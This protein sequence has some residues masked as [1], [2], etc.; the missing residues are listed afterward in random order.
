MVVK[1]VVDECSFVGRISL[2]SNERTKQDKTLY[3][4]QKR[5]IFLLFLLKTKDEIRYVPG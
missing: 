2:H 4:S 1:R 3:N 5:Y